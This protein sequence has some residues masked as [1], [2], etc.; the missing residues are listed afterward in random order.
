MGN[1]YYFA[2]ISY[3]RQDEKWAKW[4]AH[5]LEHYH[6]PTTLSDRKDLPNTLRPIFRDIDELSAGNLPQQISKA[7]KDSKYLVVICSPRAAKSKWVN[8]EVEEFINQGKTNSIF[9]FIIDGVA[10]SSDPNIEC[11][12]PALFNLPAK[13]ERLGG[14][15]NETGRDAAVVKIVAGMLNLRFDV[16]WQ[17]YER[18]KAEEERKIHEHRDKLLKIQS[19]LLSE[20]SRSLVNSGDSY[21]ARLLALES[22][23]QDLDNPSR[24]YTIEA[25]IALRYATINDNAVLKKH[26]GKV[27]AI[28]FF[29]NGTRIISASTDKSIRIWDPQSGDCTKYFNVTAP[30]Q[31][32]EIS[33]DGKY[34]TYAFTPVGLN[35]NNLVYVW[36]IINNQLQCKLYGHDSMIRALAF[37]SNGKYLA[38]ASNDGTIRIWNYKSG[39]CIQQI[40]GDGSFIMCLAFSPTEDQIAYAPLGTVVKIWDIGTRTNVM[41]LGGHTNNITCLSYSSDGNLLLTASE[42]K[43]IRV[44]NTNEWWCKNILNGHSGFILTA[45]FSPDNKFIASGSID[46]SIHIWEVSSGSVRKILLG[47]SDRI[48]ALT[49]NQNRKTL[50]TASDDT[51]IRIWDITEL[52]T[53]KINPNSI[54]KSLPHNSDDT[55]YICVANYTTLC[56]IDKHSSQI[57][58]KKEGHTDEISCAC[59]SPDDRYIASASWDKTIRIWDSMTG[60]CISILRGHL[61]CVL[62]VAF[63]PDSS[64]VISSSLD[65]TIRIWDIITGYTISSFTTPSFC[66]AYFSSDGGSIIAITQQNHGYIWKYIPLQDLINETHIRFQNVQLSIE[67]RKQY[68]LD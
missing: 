21:T 32:F 13:D 38:S 48:N 40:N 15:I 37:S 55:K 17:R 33:P 26:K 2:F 9:P 57:L 58:L 39:E 16:L 68:Y 64:L 36:D 30:V 6:L 5:E 43:T 65:N 54:F 49:F 20:K 34:L 11:F 52:Y 18:E 41:T 12:P 50:I 1:N 35:N 53:S 19:R 25:E 45:K 61:E 63:S 4:L 28:S 47:H 22:L 24:P 8:K 51:T 27:M 44:W 14:N 59:I 67:E 23:P 42:D 3:Q 62:T 60:D 66:P 29:Q 10:M 46:K 7:L 31:T 56:L